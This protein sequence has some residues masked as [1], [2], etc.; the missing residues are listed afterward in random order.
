MGMTDNLKKVLH[1][2]KCGLLMKR[3]DVLAFA[4]NGQPAVAAA[5][6]KQLLLIAVGGAGN[7]RDTTRGTLRSREPNVTSLVKK[8]LEKTP[9]IAVFADDESVYLAAPGMLSNGG[10]LRES[11]IDFI[12]RLGSSSDEPAYG[13]DE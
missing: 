2:G 7:A 4:I 10:T 1:G 6:I 11:L 13:D 3:E 5:T 8:A 12:E 9:A